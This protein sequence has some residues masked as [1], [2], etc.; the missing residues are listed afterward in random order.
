MPWPVWRVWLSGK[1]TLQEMD[2]HWSYLDLVRANEALDIDDE[3]EERLTEQN[4]GKR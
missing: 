1:A 2:T 4:E 3:I